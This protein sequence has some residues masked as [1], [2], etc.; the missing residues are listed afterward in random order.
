MA[1]AIG[2][3]A[4][5]I[6]VHECGH[7]G[8][9]RALGV[10][11]SKFAVGFGPRLFTYR[12]PEVEYSFSLIPLGGFVAF[13]DDD[14]ECPW[15]KDDPDLLR[16]RSIGDRAAVVVAGVLANVACAL[17]LLTTQALTVGQL[18]QTYLPGVR[19]PVLLGVSA[20]ERAG[21]RVGDVIL[22]VDG[23]EVAPTA[24]AVSRMVERIRTSAGAPL[25]LTLLRGGDEAPQTLQ[26]TV[27]PDVGAS[28]GGRIGVQLEG[29]CSVSCCFNSRHLCSD[30]T[31][32]A[33][34][35]HAREPPRGRQLL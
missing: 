20:A 25:R 10:H 28:G 1:E 11:V 34:S 27:T 22:A 19:V 30:V 17:A 35:K 23:E 4:G 15:P 33:R 8:M 14:P 13:P 12:G 7:F 32:R 24:S 16:N 26:L 18:E 9:A 3:L 31:A 5:I 2:V 29:A 21:V 6:F